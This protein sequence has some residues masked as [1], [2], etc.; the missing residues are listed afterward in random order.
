MRVCTHGLDESLTMRQTSASSNLSL[1]SSSM[2]LSLL[3]EWGISILMG[4][5]ERKDFSGM[6][7]RENWTWIAW[8]SPRSDSGLFADDDDDDDDDDLSFWWCF[9]SA[10]TALLSRAESTILDLSLSLSAT[11]MD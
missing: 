1:S 6:R 3:S 4:L 9:K 8:S 5:S 11:M 7:V 10:F 2:S